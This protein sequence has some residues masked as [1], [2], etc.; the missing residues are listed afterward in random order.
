MSIV[1]YVLSFLLFSGPVFSTDIPTETHFRLP[2]A[3]SQPFQFQFSEYAANKKYRAALQCEVNPVKD[4][5]TSND[6]FLGFLSEESL[7]SLA[8]SLQ[9]VGIGENNNTLKGDL[10]IADLINELTQKIPSD[11]GE[12]QIGEYQIEEYQKIYSSAD[13][14]ELLFIYSMAFFLVVLLALYF[15]FIQFFSSKRLASLFQSSRFYIIVFIVLTLIVGS[16]LVFTRDILKFNKQYA[17][18]TAQVNLERQLSSKIE[19]FDFFMN[20]HKTHLLALSQDNQLLQITQALLALPAQYEALHQSAALAQARVFFKQ[21]KVLFGELG[22]FIIDADNKSIASQR[23]S[24]LGLENFITQYYP[25]R[26]QK[27]W[28]GEVVFIPPVRS[29]VNLLAKGAGRA[30]YL[31]FVA[32]IRNAKGKVIALLTQRLETKDLYFK[33]PSY[34]TLSKLLDGYILDAT[35]RIISDKS[36]VFEWGQTKEIAEKALDDLPPVTKMTQ[37]IIKL[38]Q[39]AVEWDSSKKPTIFIDLQGYPNALGMEVIGAWAWSE[40][41]GVGFAFEMSVEQA[42]NNYFEL[43]QK[44]LIIIFFSLLVLL[45]AIILMLS[46]GKKAAGVLLGKQAD[47]EQEIAQ[48]IKELKKLTVIVEQSPM[49]IVMTNLDAQIEYVNPEFCR[50][51]GYQFNEVVGQNPNILQSPISDKLI[52]NKMWEIL[53]RGKIWRGELINQRKNGQVY[54]ENTIIAPIRGAD[55]KI[56]SYVAVKE[57]ITERKLAEEQNMRLGRILENS[58]N[59]I[60]IFDAKSLLF[61]QANKGAL[62]NIGYSMQELEKLTPV[63]I[64]PSFNWDSFIKVIEPL[65]KGK[66]PILSFNTIHQ[67]KNGSIYPIEVHLQ[68]AVA[69]LSSVFVATVQDITVR[70]ER[71]QEL[72]IAKEDAEQANQAKSKFLANMSH[73]L[74][75]PLNAI[76]GFAQVMEADESL[77]E[78]HQENLRIINQ[79]GAHLLNLINDILDL[80]KIEAEEVEIVLG[81]VNIIKLCDSLESLFKQELIK[82][83]L[84]LS[85]D[86]MPANLVSVMTDKTKLWQILVNLMNNAIKFTQVGGVVVRVHSTEPLNNKLNLQVEVEDTGCGIAEQDLKSIFGDFVQLE[87]DL[88]KQ[89]GTGLGLAI[90]HNM[91]A[92]M[93]GQL[94]VESV[95]GQGAC[96]KF[97]L[98]CQQAKDSLHVI[99]KSVLLPVSGKAPSYFRIL[100]VDDNL[101]NRLLLIK[102]LKPLGFI[103]KETI[104]GAEAVEVCKVWQPHLVL[105]DIRMPIMDGYEATRQIKAFKKDIIIFAV[106]ASVFKDK[107]QCIKDSGADDIITKPFNVTELLSTIEQY[108]NVTYRSITGCADEVPFNLEK[109]S[110]KVLDS[111][112]QEQLKQAITYVDIQE[113]M[114][115]LGQI[116]EIDTVLAEAIQSKMDVFAYDELLN[117]LE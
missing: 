53:K 109:A 77:T 100:V 57:D 87:N 84:T 26:I 51:T 11:L 20:E 61:I 64:K 6:F 52:Y 3:E 79:S 4:F 50:V 104:N 42:L 83:K 39:Q 111:A 78:R 114:C 108:L 117:L 110:F 23:N 27:A 36:K 85:F 65:R 30:R 71:E 115:L 81:S 96:F 13:Q 97:T 88:P 58:L 33:I 93:G 43:R 92:K 91:V 37:E 69:E 54:W 38:S 106:T 82:K 67:R 59:E 116:S 12:H 66:V 89:Q 70:Q 113:M 63:D 102:I 112:L 41:L 101:V 75:T 86:I 74:R 2:S 45:T 21:R 14:I 103:C 76:L 72:K 19:S 48:Q 10:L 60:Y 24:N 25:K 34:K 107:Y 5:I 80:S 95:V 73:E 56:E 17:L 18:T 16:T 68:L 62:D 31:F 35:G 7:E 98:E 28:Q 32:P 47:L 94:L 46:F 29:D 40:E 15:I 1:V 22:F 9:K 90:C 8:T 105:M 99:E 49:S 44:L 55:N